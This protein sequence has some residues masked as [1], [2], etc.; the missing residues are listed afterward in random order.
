LEKK[1]KGVDVGFNFDDSTCMRDGNNNDTTTGDE[2]MEAATLSVSD[3]QFTTFILTAVRPNGES[4]TVGVFSNE[5]D[6]NLEARNLKQS[7]NCTGFTLT[8]IAFDL[9]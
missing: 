8:E 2:T 5:S 7:S 4:I 6:G 9:N 1:Q 3:N